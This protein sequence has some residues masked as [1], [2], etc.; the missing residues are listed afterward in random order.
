M[1]YSFF[2]VLVVDDDLEK[3]TAAGRATRAVI[4]KLR[5]DGLSV[6]EAS[7]YDDGEMI[8]HSNPGIGCLMLEWGCD[9]GE[10]A[11][12]PSSWSPTGACWPSCRTRR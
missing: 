6:I 5:E 8:L 12:C 4:A 9:G 1:E 3:T 10:A 2:P 7:S 11:R